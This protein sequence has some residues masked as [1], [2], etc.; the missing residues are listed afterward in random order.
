MATPSE[1]LIAAVNDGRRRACRRARRRGPVAGVVARPRRRVGDHAL[2]LPFQPRDD[3]RAAGR[4]SRPRRLRGDG[5]RVHRS[6]PG[7]AD[8]GSGVGARRSRRTDSP[9]CITRGSSARSRRLVSS[10]PP[11]RRSTSTPRTRSPTS[12]CMRPR[13]AATMR[14]AACCWGLAPTS[15]PPS[16]AGTRRCTRPPRAATS[17]SPSCSCRRVPTPTMRSDAAETPAETAEAAGHH[18]LAARI[19]EVAEAR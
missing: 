11:G 9:R 6:A 10:S 3:R 16:T 12:R 18:D 17:S 4:R 1:E 8:G 7:T 19:R 14:S 2:A 15:M 5:A 13:P